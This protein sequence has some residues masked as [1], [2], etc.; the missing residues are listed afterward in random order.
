MSDGFLSDRQRDW[1]AIVGLAIGLAQILAAA[2]G[3]LLTRRAKRAT[4]EASPRR[5]SAS[6]RR[7]PTSAAVA[8]GSLLVSLGSSWAASQLTLVGTL[9]MIIAPFA[10]FAQW[11]ALIACC[12]NALFDERVDGSFAQL[13]P[14]L[15]RWSV[16][17]CSAV[18]AAVV[19]NHFGP[20]VDAQ[21]VC[22]F[23]A[24]EASGLIV[25]SLAL[26]PFTIADTVEWRKDR[27]AAI[28]KGRGG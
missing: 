18:V 17:G 24:G 23:A 5:Q 14:V 15:V 4:S 10:A 22:R 8:V 1:I 9:C 2:I 6:G 25:L 12:E 3:W 28:V 20:C 16:L 7:V 27:R 19:I 26:T 11:I 21:W 13:R